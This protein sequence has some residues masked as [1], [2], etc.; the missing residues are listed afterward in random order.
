VKVYVL[1]HVHNFADGTEDV[2]FIE[3]YS[4]PKRVQQA[5]KRL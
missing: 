3:V 2:K 5:V 4:T 1:H